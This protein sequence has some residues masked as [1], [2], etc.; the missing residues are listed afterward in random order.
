MIK[1]CFS[2]MAGEVEGRRRIVAYAASRERTSGAMI[3]R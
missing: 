3:E 2:D 1:T